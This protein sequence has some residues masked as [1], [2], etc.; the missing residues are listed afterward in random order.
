M[1]LNI[2]EKQ[3][4]SAI[5]KTLAERTQR[6]SEGDII[7]YRV[8]DLDF[9]RA[10]YGLFFVDDLGYYTS[11]DQATSYKAKDAKR[12]V[13]SSEARVWDPVKELGLEVEYWSK[14]IGLM[15]VFKKYGIE[16]ECDYE[17]DE[18]YGVTSTDGL[19][20]V[21]HRLGYDAMVVRE[22]ACISPGNY[23]NEYVVFNKDM[24]SPF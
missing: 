14:I 23:A 13:L 21:G 20:I 2:N 22:T 18:R 19:T 16:D 3:L 15:S 10:K 4:R 6:T 24:I 8:G 5:R 17:M 1:K 7:L 11:H 9:D 12:Y